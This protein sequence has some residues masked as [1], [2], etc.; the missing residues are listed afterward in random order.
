MQMSP[1][2]KPKRFKAYRVP[3]KL[4][5]ALSAEIQKLLKLGFIERIDSPQAS[6]I[7]CVMKG[8]TVEDGIRLVVDYRYVNRY[9]QDSHQPLESIPDL[10][11]KIGQANYISKFD[12]RSGYWQTKTEPSQ[13]WIN[14]FICE[15]GQFAWTR[16]PFELKAAGHTFVKA[17]RQVIQPVRDFTANY[18]DDSAVYSDDWNS[19][20]YHLERFLTEIKKS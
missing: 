12:A 11:H 3:E 20:L 1:E 4:K 15:E 14:S 13:R 8:K 2:F 18:V 5:P 9:T 6:P 16:T 17:M 19:H 10:V 7:V